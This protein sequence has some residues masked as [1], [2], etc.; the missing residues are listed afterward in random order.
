MARMKNVEIVMMEWAQLV[1]DGVLEEDESLYTY[2]AWKDRG[3]QVRKGETAIAKFP[4]WNYSK[5]KPKENESGEVEQ[6]KG[7]YFYMKMTAFFCDRQVDP[8]ME[9]ETP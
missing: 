7:G 6:V 8:I 3:F 2:K 9:D 5:R 1:A 4:I